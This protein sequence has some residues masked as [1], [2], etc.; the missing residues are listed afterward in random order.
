MNDI[1]KFSKSIEAEKLKRLRVRIILFLVIF[2]VVWIVFYLLGTNDI[3]LA[4]FY[5]FLKDRITERL[6]PD[7]KDSNE[8]KGYY[9]NKGIKE[10]INQEI[11]LTD[12]ILN[13]ILT[14][15]LF[16][17]LPLY[18]KR[19][20]D[21]IIKYAEEI[22]PRLS[23]YFLRHILNF[24]IY[25]CITTLIFSVSAPYVDDFFELGLSINNKAEENKMKKDILQNVITTNINQMNEYRNKEN[26]YKF[27]KDEDT[28][29]RK[30]ISTTNKENA[31]KLKGQEEDTK[32]EEDSSKE[33]E[34]S[35]KEEEDKDLKHIEKDSS[36]EELNSSDKKKKKETIKKETIK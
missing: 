35:T 31:K 3:F 20:R 24:F 21:L 8:V 34:D 27:K 7:N 14:K 18:D 16:L 32:E 4:L 19:K 11:N 26:F 9:K 5:Y 23:K 2:L 36:K 6:F 33:E 12:P 1:E 25:L 29:E 17:E 13:I 30:S 22:N 15:S 28:K 10:R